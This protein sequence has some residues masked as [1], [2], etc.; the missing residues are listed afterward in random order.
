MKNTL[1]SS[2]AAIGVAAALVI[3]MT[4]GAEARDRRPERDALTVD[5]SADQADARIAILKADLR[6]TP[7]QAQHWTGLSSAL[8]DIAVKREKMGGG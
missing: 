3:P 7:D 6:L 8:H 4:S 5:Q 1:V 2:F